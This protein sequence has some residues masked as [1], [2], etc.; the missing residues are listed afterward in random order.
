[1]SLQKQLGDYKRELA[2]TAARNSAYTRPQTSAD[3][4]KRSHETA[5]SNSQSNSSAA[6]PA[7]TPRAP[8]PGSAGTELLTQVYYAIDYLKTKGNTAVP[9]DDITNYLSLPV[10]AQKHI[11]HIREA[12]KAHDRVAFVP[13]SESGN[14][15]DSFKYRPPHPVSNGEEL[16]AYLAR[17]PTSQGIPV[18]ELKDG[19]PDCVATIDALE[20]EGH[21]LVIRNKK[22]DTPKMVWFDSPTY[23][24]SIDSDFADFW[25]KTKLP[26]TENEIRNELEKAGLTC[27]SQVKEIKK[28]EIKK[29]RKRV[30]RRGG[31]TTNHHMSGILKDYS[32]R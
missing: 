29:D 21:V 18:R 19:W 17:Q 23:H 25:N 11:P 9:F 6:A 24:I 31:K 4:P 1:M 28:L 7:S 10:D 13:K 26:S 12:L 30:N 16:K 5:F 20:K 27:T 15:K 2:D 8:G 22:D 32:K 14:G 3:I